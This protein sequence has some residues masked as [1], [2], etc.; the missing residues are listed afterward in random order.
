MISAQVVSRIP[1]KETDHSRGHWPSEAFVH[2]VIGARMLE[3]YGYSHTVYVDADAWPLDDALRFE[4]PRVD[5]I[6]CVAALPAQCLE[7]R[8]SPRRRAASGKEPPLPPRLSL[9]HI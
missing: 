4:V 8:R 7:V 1:G 3:E 2:L 5:G 6:G 9:I